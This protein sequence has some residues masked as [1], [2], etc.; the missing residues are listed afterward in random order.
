MD[1]TESEASLYMEA[2]SGPELGFVGV[3]AFF[4]RHSLALVGGAFIGGVL[5]LWVAFTLPVQWEANVLIQVGQ[6]WN[7]GFIEPPIR[8]IERIKSRGFEKAVSARM[9]VPLSEASS[10]R[11]NFN[12]DLMGKTELLKL[13][14]QG[15]SR[16]AAEQLARAAMVEL[17]K[18]HLQM[19]MPTINRWREELDEVNSELKRVDIELAR[20]KHLSDKKTSILNNENF[21]SAILAINILSSRDAQIR[22]LQERKYTIEDRLSPERTFSTTDWGVDVSDRPVSPR[23][24]IYAAAGLVSGLLIGMLLSV[25][26]A[27]RNEKNKID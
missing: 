17:S 26:I 9:G 12:V 1:G 3:V 22:T 23:K 4:K 20:I 8:V 18:T 10:H 7:G 19:M 16:E 14:V 5:G 15:K 2:Q 13:R 11:Y 27:R 24:S 25:V 21:Y 6:V